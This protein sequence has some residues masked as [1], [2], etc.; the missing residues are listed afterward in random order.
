MNATNIGVK[1]FFFFS[2]FDMDN[3]A[4]FSNNLGNLVTFTLEK[5]R[6]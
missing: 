1:V 6:H 4:I 3:L 5:Y 2:I